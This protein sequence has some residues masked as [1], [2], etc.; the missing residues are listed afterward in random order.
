MADPLWLPPSI[1]SPLAGQPFPSPN[2]DPEARRVR[3]FRGETAGT[4]Q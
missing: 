1:G 3:L 4:L 2:P